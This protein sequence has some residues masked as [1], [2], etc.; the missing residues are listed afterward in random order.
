MGSLFKKYK[1]VVRF[2]LL[3]LGTYLVLSFLYGVFLHESES[4]KYHPDLLTFL[5]G[6]QSSSII[7]G[8]NYEAEVMP[9]LN[10]PRSDLFINGTSVAQIIEGCNS[11]SVII[12][13]MAFVIAFSQQV[14]KTIIFIFA[15]A[16]ILYCINIIRIVLLSILLY[17]YPQYSEFLHGVV[18]PSIIYGT[19][20]ILWMIWVRMLK[21]YAYNEEER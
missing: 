18:F 2:V 7:S 3:F 20:F 6:K 10:A 17:E 8:F 19:V 21:T 14:K 15:G 12:L 1:P 13:F 11:I 4:Q 16:V 9:V 5:V